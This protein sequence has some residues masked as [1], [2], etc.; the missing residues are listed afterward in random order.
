VGNVS[1]HLVEVLFLSSIGLGPLHV[2]VSTDLGKA[3]LRNPCLLFLRGERLL[4]S[5]ELLLTHKQQLLQFL[6]RHRHRHRHGDARRKRPTQSKHGQINNT[7]RNKFNCHKEWL[8]PY[9][10][11]ACTQWA[12]AVIVIR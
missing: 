8:R 7:S 9:L 11:T 4:A 2:E 1:H 10:S 3:F 6:N 12:P 5:R